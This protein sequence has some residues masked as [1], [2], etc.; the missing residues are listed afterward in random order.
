[1]KSLTLRLAMLVIAIIL[2]AFLAY[3]CTN[4]RSA[5]T[6]NKQNE[7][8]QSSSS[9]EK[10][11]VLLKFGVK[12]LQAR[13]DQDK[14]YVYYVGVKNEQRKVIETTDISSVTLELEKGDIYV[15]GIAKLVDEGYIKTIGIVGHP[16]V[17]LSSIPINVDSATVID[18]GQLVSEGM[19]L[20]PE[21]L[22][23]Q[24]FASDVGF[25]LET[26]EDFGNF[27]ISLRK[28][29]NLD[30]NR[31][32]VLDSEEG[33][34]WRLKPFYYYIN[35]DDYSLEY[36]DIEYQEGM[37]FKWFI[38]IKTNIEFKSKDFGEDVQG[39]IAT[40]T[41]IKPDGTKKI[42]PLT[43]D[44][45]TGK[46]EDDPEYWSWVFCPNF[47][48]E[49]APPW[50][51]DY[52]LEAEDTNGEVNRFYFDNLIYFTPADMFKGM[53]FPAYQYTVYSDG[54][55]KSVSWRWF[56][57]KSNGY[58]KVDPK[59]A[60]LVSHF[61]F[62]GSAKAS[63]YFHIPFDDRLIVIDTKDLSENPWADNDVDLSNE[64]RWVG[65]ESSADH[66][67]ITGNQAMFIIDNAF[68]TIPHD[69]S[70]NVQL[71]SI[72]STE[73]IEGTWINLGYYEKD[74]H[75]TP[76]SILFYDDGTIVF[77][78]DFDANE[79]G[80]YTLDPQDP[81]KIK[82]EI[83]GSTYYI[84][85]KVART[86]MEMNVSDQDFP[87]EIDRNSEGYRIYSRYDPYLPIVENPQAN[88]DGG[89]ATFTWDVNDEQY[90]E[91]DRFKVC[92]STNESD[93]RDL[94]EN[95]PCIETETHEANISLESGTYYWRVITIGKD[96][97]ELPG[98]I[99]QENV[100]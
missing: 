85:A 47:D 53:I 71:Y 98:P 14:Y 86:Y 67:D 79:T 26:L 84:L 28:F 70:E 87:T 5:L 97:K 46:N 36:P 89:S 39:P 73:T 75:S 44:G 83:G 13:A 30:I 62:L 37:T 40:L 11:K 22:S 19:I 38:D 66:E 2:L 33:L 94:N 52:I 99:Y 60:E 61:F 96:G 45:A 49:D 58:T 41:C 12:S 74:N 25:D 31:N 8:S 90:F 20:K 17:G 82:I 7:S 29:I 34:D 23:A 72:P 4:P 18:L 35:K 55:V 10:G 15:I 43:K 16:D 9:I 32:G 76:V 63:K 27:D 68:L 69:F 54:K 48:A 50:N 65:L 91:I 93:V 21:A 92:Y 6:T 56:L 100:P 95:V 3:S 1:V 77:A 88:V 51:G 42:V 80:T 78:Y 57:K 59:V 24:D 64:D 81:S